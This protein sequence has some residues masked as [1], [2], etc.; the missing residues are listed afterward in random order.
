MSGSSELLN[1]MLSI[2]STL[3][4]EENTKPLEVYNITYFNLLGKEVKT[5][6]KGLYIKVMQTNKGQVAEKIYFR[7]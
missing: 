5:L 6:D 2:N 4:I 3:S 7:D 1:E